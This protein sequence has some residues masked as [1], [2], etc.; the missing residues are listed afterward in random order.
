M[1]K[2]A[3]LILAHHNYGQLRRLIQFLDSPEADIYLH[4]D[5]KARGFDQKAFRSLC[6][7]SELYLMPR[8][9]LSWGGSSLT[10]MEIRMLRQAIPKGYGHYH[11]LSGQD[12]PLRPLEELHQFF[13]THP[14]QEF[15]GVNWDDTEKPGIYGRIRYYYLLQ[16]LT[17]SRDRGPW[18]VIWEIQHNLVNLQKKLGVDRCR[19]FPLKLGKGSQWFSITHGF[20]CHVVDLYGRVLKGS[21]RY[22]SGSDELLVQTAIL[23]EPFYFSRL[24]PLGNMRCIDWSRS[25]NGCSPYTFTAEDLHELMSSGKLWA[26]KVSESVDNTLIE[27]IYDK[28]NAQM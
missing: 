13:E 9:R 14:D 3:Y 7:H 5:R 24:S 27:K 15:V 19:N 23:N 10:D 6:Q 4:M 25:K 20:A 17:G 8:R 11:L 21:F 18:A 26:R 16:N 1:K 12:I 22:S 28:I 2:H